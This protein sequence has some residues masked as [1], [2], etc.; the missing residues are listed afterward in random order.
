MWWHRTGPSYGEPTSNQLIGYEDA[1]TSW[2]STSGTWRVGL[3]AVVLVLC[4]VGGVSRWIP[5][6]LGVAAAG[7][8]TRLPRRPIVVSVMDNY[9]QNPTLLYKVWPRTG[10]K[11]LV[12]RGIWRG[13]W[14]PNARRIAYLK[15]SYWDLEYRPAL[16][17]RDGSNKRVLS[18]RAAD[19]NPPLTW[20]DSRRLVY[21]PTNAST[22]WQDFL[23]LRSDGSRR[24]IYENEYTMCP[25]V[26]PS[27]ERLVYH[28]SSW[29][30]YDPDPEDI[31]VSRLDGTSERVVVDGVHVDEMLWSP[32]G[33][34]IAY[35]E[36]SFD[37]R[38][39]GT[40]SD[41]YLVSPDGSASRRLTFN[42]ELFEEEWSWSPDGRWIAFRGHGDG[43]GYGVY[44]VRVSDGRLR[45]L[46]STNGQ[47]GATP[48]WSR[49]S[50]RLAYA[51][52][53]KLFMVGV[54]GAR[55]RVIARPPR[56]W[57]FHPNWY[58]EST[59]P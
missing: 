26:S 52:D 17:R 20:A 46:A 11:K 24:P 37:E 42:P 5:G 1:V 45:R 2:K 30:E 10:K 16:M 6:G 19:R 36:I 50:S 18:R 32:R 48:T 13:I 3:P 55:P 58:T 51:S 12:G 53:R 56:G 22:T 59:C 21:A 4:L 23:L 38:G 40:L 43:T 49:D 7:E 57:F 47:A 35:K 34:L 9:A 25:D 33:G 8:P 41:L 27:G 28:H 14:S 39:A 31:R 15:G 29:D 54:N 44:V